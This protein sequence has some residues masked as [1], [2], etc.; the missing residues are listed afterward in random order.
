MARIIKTINNKQFSLK[1]LG[2][3]DGFTIGLEISKLVLPALGASVDGMRKDEIIHGAPQTFGDAAQKLVQQ[4]GSVDVLNIIDKMFAGMTVDDKEIDWDEY[5]S[6]NYAEM[7]E[8]LMFTLKEN[9]ESFF[10]ESGIVQ[11]VQTFLKQ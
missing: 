8:V 3:R 2:A 7:V 9:F 6:G 11:K 1:K 10:T 4:M 5:F